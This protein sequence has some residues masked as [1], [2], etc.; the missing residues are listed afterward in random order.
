M[1]HCVHQLVSNCVFGARQ[2]EQTGILE[3]FSYMLL[4]YM[5]LSHPRQ[6]SSSLASVIES[7]SYMEPK[8]YVRVFMAGKKVDD[9]CKSEPK[10]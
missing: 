6:V 7:L 5:L 4:V 2:A 10:Q 8:G 1:L 9:G 3:L